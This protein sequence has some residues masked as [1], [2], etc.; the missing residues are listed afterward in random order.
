MS[1][2]SAGVTEIA[3]SWTVEEAI[4]E[5]DRFL[6]LAKAQGAQLRPDLKG[7]SFPSAPSHP[8]RGTG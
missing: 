3:A 1:P 2:S 5:A 8:A 7:Q 6:Y 4:A